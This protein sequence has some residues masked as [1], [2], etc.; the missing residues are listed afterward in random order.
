MKALLFAAG[1]GK[2][3]RPLTDTRPKALVEVAGKTLL[4]WNIE[5][6]VTAGVSTIVVNVHSFAQQI[7]DFVK[8]R[9]WGAD[10]LFSDERDLLLETGG[11]LLKAAPLL[12]DDLPFFMYN[13]DILSDIDLKAMYAFH[14]QKQALVTLAVQTRSGSRQFL[15]DGSG[16]LCGWTN[17]EKQET[18]MA[19]QSS[20]I[21]QPLAFSGIH[22]ANP[23][24]LDMITEQGVFSITD[25][26][27][28]LAATQRI[29]AFDHSQGKWFDIGSPEKLAKASL[30]FS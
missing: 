24:L 6:L 23:A 28:R 12:R 9:A 11:G 27:L 15:W 26:Y 19:Y 4:Q 1:L 7:I 20:E 5:K 14:L 21:P 30:G 13:V 17:T 16:L 2:R 22:I 3:L 10:I 18:R 25:V 29:A 8:A